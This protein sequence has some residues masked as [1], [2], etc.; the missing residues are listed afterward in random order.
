M[1]HSAPPVDSD[2]RSLARVTLARAH[3]RFSSP[4]RLAAG[5]RTSSKNT[6]LNVWM[7][8]MSTIG[9]ISMPGRSMGQTK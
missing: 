7:P 1:P 3:P 5:M 4:T 9:R 8:V 6:S 2:T